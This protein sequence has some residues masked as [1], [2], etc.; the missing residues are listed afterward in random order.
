M[1]G[2][3]AMIVGST[4]VVSVGKDGSLLVR[5]DADDHK[6]LL[7]DPGTAQADMGTGRIMG[8]GWIRVRPEATDDDRLTFW[9]DTAMTYNRAIT[10]RRS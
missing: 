5:A 3:R 1:F 10:T 7:A 4:M 9:V 2:G 6:A 8:P